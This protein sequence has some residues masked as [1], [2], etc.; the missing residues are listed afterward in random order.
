VH[1]G[2]LYAGRVDPVPW[3][4]AHGVRLGGGC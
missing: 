2:G 3:L 1:E 4:G